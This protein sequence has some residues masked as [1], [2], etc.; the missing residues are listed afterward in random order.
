MKTHL[1]VKQSNTLTSINQLLFSHFASSLCL[2]QSGSQLL[3]L[4][5]HQ[6]ISALHHGNLLLHVF[7][8]SHSIIKVQLGILTFQR[9]K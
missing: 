7:L 1:R 6:A 8:S 3:D 2:V 4:S 9:D 5:H